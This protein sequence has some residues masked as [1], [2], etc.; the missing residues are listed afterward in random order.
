MNEKFQYLCTRSK[1]RRFIRETFEDTEEYGINLGPTQQEVA[2]KFFDGDCHTALRMLDD[3]V[4]LEY[5]RRVL[6]YGLYRWIPGEVPPKSKAGNSSVAASI[7][8]EVT[9]RILD[10][11]TREFQAGVEGNRRMLPSTR[12]VAKACLRGK[13]PTML[14][15][16]NRHLAAL[17]QDGSIIKIQDPDDS[18]WHRTYWALPD[19]GRAIPGGKE[20]V[21]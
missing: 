8:T 10:Y 17:E 4:R 5:A 12:D 18:R 2:D 9:V 13:S 21:S 3:L 14:R 6:S 15:R 1:V 20:S 16:A 19:S 7:R 11:V